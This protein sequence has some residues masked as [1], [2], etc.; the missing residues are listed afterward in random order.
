MEKTESEKSTSKIG[1]LSFYLMLTPIILFLIVFI[2]KLTFDL[3]E[4]EDVT[5]IIS[6]VVVYSTTLFP[7]SVLLSFISF[8]Q[9]NRKRKIPLFTFI[10]TIIPVT[11]FLSKALIGGYI[12]RNY[13]KSHKDTIIELNPMIELDFKTKE[14]IYKIRNDAVFKYKEIINENYAPSEDVFGGIV[15]NK[16]WWGIYG[17][18]YYGPGNKSIEGASEESR[19]IT[20]PY[21]LVGVKEPYVYQMSNIVHKPIAFP[22]QPS[23]LIWRKDSSVVV[24]YN[25][26]E[27][28]KKMR[29]Y[30]YFRNEDKLISLVAYN[31]RD[32][33]LNYI[34]IDENKSE[35]IDVLNKSTKPKKITH[36]LHLGTS[37]GYTGG[38]NNQSPQFPYLDEIRVKD[39]PAK[40]YIKLWAHDP[41]KYESE[42]R[43]KYII[44]LK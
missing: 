10:L 13:L 34:S 15:S 44:N 16:A 20:N 28:F 39:L 25:M 1:L 30:K 36:Y 17:H 22:P 27:Y 12:D 35:N 18:Y 23:N 38:G 2:L 32:L 4:M 42:P 40:I 26:S 24:D 14:E 41:I 29:D 11:I 21:L 37:C 43:I 5:D 33:R 31:A 9:K 19:F 3:S 7:A 6:R 8:F